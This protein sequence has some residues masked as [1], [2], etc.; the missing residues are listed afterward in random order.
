MK[1][2]YRLFPN[3]AFFLLLISVVVIFFYPFIFYGKIPIPADTIVGM[4][5][6][7]RD[8]IWNGYTQG[9]PVKNPLITDPVRQQYVWRYTSIEQMRSGNLPVWNPYS[10]SGT[11][12]LANFQ[13]A[14]LYP[15]NILFF[16]FPYHS[17]WGILVLLQQLLAGIFL[18][19]YLRY[20]KVSCP[21]SFLGSISFIF[22]GF[23]TAWLEWNTVGHVMLWLPFILY[24]Q[25]RLLHKV[26]VRWILLLIFAQSAQILAGHLQILFYAQ[27]LSTSYLL[28]RI[29]QINRQSREYSD[30][31]KFIVHFFGKMLP[32]LVVSIIVIS[33]TSIQ[34]VPSL[35]FIKISGRNFDQSNVMKEGWYLPWQNLVQFIAPDFFGNPVTNNYYGVWNY[36][37]F[38][39]YVGIIPLFFALLAIFRLRDKKTIFFGAATLVGLLFSLPTVIASLPYKLNIPFV[40]LS[41]PSR[42][43]SIVDFSLCVLA[44]YGFDRFLKE[45]IRK[46]PFFLCGLLVIIIFSLWILVNS[47]SIFS[48]NIS[49]SYLKVSQ[50]NLIFPTI[51]SLFSSFFI[52]LYFVRI[53]FMK[54]IAVT[55]IVFLTIVDLLRFSSK[56]T[57]FMD[58]SWLYPKTA[59]LALMNQDKNTWRFMS[60]DRR[61]MP[62]NFS[63]F[64]K[65][66]DVSG[67]DPLYL[68]LYGQLVAAW[69]RNSS[70]ISPAAFNRILTPM[71]YEN[72]FSDLLGVKYLMSLS[73]I[74]SDKLSLVATEGSTYLYR[75]EK[76]FPRAFFASKIIKVNNIQEEIEQMYK[77]S[78]KLRYIAVTTEDIRITPR[79]LLPGESV[80]LEKYSDNYIN[81]TT[82]STVDRLVVVA[83]IYYPLWKAAIDGRRSIL[84]RVD[85]TLRGIVVPKGIHTIEL[86][87]E[88]I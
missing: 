3:S 71:G 27:A 56:F 48:V 24:T 58:S 77:L 53:P 38:V 76:A 85:F 14:A 81:I 82:K 20:L 25:E 43:L 40:S 42:L 5:H 31:K 32:F 59:L 75:N 33:I 50:R 62:S 28:A 83:D 44:A 63:V 51:I 35:Q 12:L 66:Q 7:W 10:F 34:W 88:I 8:N 67:Y 74:R 47:Q 9:V 19:K 4:Y 55:A 1:K 36:G 54:I 87:T 72:I 84:H 73:P 13:S 52:L 29:F 79:E 11:P 86:F 30:A 39:G 15:L 69:E 49:L 65:I 46:A 78:D 22:S 45:K 60:L 37:E 64:Y 70:D 61:V 26:S 17:A 80:T 23:M 16:L 21:A 2:Y 57:P 18:Y 6:P 41:Q 68:L